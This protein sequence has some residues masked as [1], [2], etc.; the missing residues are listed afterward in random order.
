MRTHF[1]CALPVL[2]CASLLADLSLRAADG[3]VATNTPLPRT[4]A[5]GNPLR[6]APT[7]HVSNYDESKVGNYTLPD[8]LVL[9]DGKPVRDAQT[10]FNVRRPELLKLYDTDIYGRVPASAPKA[11]FKAV[12]TDTNGLDGMAVRKLV[13]I[14]FGDKPDGPAVQLHIYLPAKAT[15]PVPVLL[16][17]VFSANLPASNAVPPGPGGR[18]M[19][20]ETGPLT[21][22]LARGYGYATFRYTEVQTGFLQHFSIRRHQPG[23]RTGPGQTRARRMGNHQRL[24]MGRE[25]R[26]RLFGDGSG[27]GRQTRRAHRP[28]APRQDGLAGGR[29]GPAVRAHLFQLRRRD[30]FRARPARLRR[31]D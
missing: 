23:A 30:G 2:L 1:I 26:A 9:A 7:G 5:N 18:P 16:Q 8:P 21:N 22:I 4:D 24:G 6:R 13:L 10:W 31:N 17:I 12:E 25:P 3:T 28:F 20:G 29:A 27:G 11:T 14:Q 15:R 19:S